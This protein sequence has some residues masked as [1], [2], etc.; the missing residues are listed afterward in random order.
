MGMNDDNTLAPRREEEER[1]LAKL[2]WQ[3]VRNL[4]RR[5]H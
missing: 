2:A 4:P 1:L 5:G 3:H